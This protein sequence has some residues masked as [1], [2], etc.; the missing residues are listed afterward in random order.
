MHILTHYYNFKS[1]Q[2]DIKQATWE[3]SDLMI[4][5]IEKKQKL[6]NFEWAGGSTVSVLLVEQ[7]HQ[8]KA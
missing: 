1:K 5:W 8:R 6:H 4:F 7:K 2:L 3:G